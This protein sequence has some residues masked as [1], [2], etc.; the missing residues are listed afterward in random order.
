MLREYFTLILIICVSLISCSQKEVDKFENAPPVIGKKT[1]GKKP[2]IK[3]RP[4]SRD[5]D[6][7]NILKN[8]GFLQ[9]LRSESNLIMED[10]QSSCKDA[11]LQISLAVKWT[12][13][14]KKLRNE[15]TMMDPANKSALSGPWIRIIR[16]ITR[17][18]PVIAKEICSKDKGAQVHIQ[19]VSENF[20]GIEQYLK[21]IEKK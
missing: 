21:K 19:S 16:T 11:D 20:T 8:K 12:P 6:R 2:R 13:L 15:V 14:E 7:E 5:W 9:K 17:V 18:W 1:N 3:N 10:I 4:S